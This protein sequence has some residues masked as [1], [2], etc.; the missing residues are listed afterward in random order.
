MSGGLVLGRMSYLPYDLRAYES[1]D[2]RGTLALSRTEQLPMVHT[3]SDAFCN[4]ET[5]HGHSFEFL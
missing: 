4:F 2:V 1:N 3:M 5:D